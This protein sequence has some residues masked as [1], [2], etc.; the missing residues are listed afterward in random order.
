MPTPKNIDI[1]EDDNSLEIRIRWRYDIFS[2]FLL[3]FALG[4]MGLIFSMTGPNLRIILACSLH[5]AVGYWMFHTAISAIF[6]STILKVYDGDLQS[7][8]YP[9]PSW[10][11]SRLYGIHEIDQVFVKENISKSSSGTRYSYSVHAQLIDNTEK[12]LLDDYFLTSEQALFV[13]RKLE[14]HLGIIDKAIPEEY[15]GKN[16]QTEE[17]EGPRRIRTSYAEAFLTELFQ[18]KL[19][20]SVTLQGREYIVKQ[21]IQNDWPDDTSDR[22]LQLAD[23]NQEHLQL[24]I[25]T[26]KTFLFAYAERS[27]TP[28]AIKSLQFTVNDIPDKLFLTKQP[29][30]RI[31]LTYSAYCRRVVLPYRMARSG[32]LPN[33]CR[34]DWDW[35]H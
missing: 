31:H 27:L 20:D 18:L 24:F 21:R 4:W 34:C 13:E 14:E 26:Y 6:N 17:A 8:Q 11:S 16:R 9:I 7:Y 28:A 32:P 12:V 33:S 5:L 23:I 3:L 22:I 35:T 19:G 30:A 10:F 25:N 29:M 1:R 2:Y 15:S